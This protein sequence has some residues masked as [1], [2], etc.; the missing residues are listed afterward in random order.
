[1]VSI[2]EVRASNTRITADT[3]PHTAVFTGA[4]DG[5]GKASLTRLI[6]TKLPV[7]VYVIGRN[8]EKHKAF[9]DEL[10]GFNKQA[11][12]IWL[13]GQL[14][15][16]ADTKRLCDEIKAREKCIDTLYMSAGF[17]SGERL[18]T[19]E[20]NALSQSLTYYSRVLMM[21]QLLPLLKASPNNPRVVS[22]LNAGNETTSI[23][24]DDLN[25]KKPGN[26]TLVNLAKSTSTYTTLTM[27]KI[28]KENPGVTFIHHYP[29]GVSTDLF[30]K[31][32]GNKWYW[33]LFGLA[34]SILGTSPEDAAEKILYMITSAKYGGKGVA[35]AAGQSPGLTMAKTKQADSL[36]A[37]NDKLK[38]LQQEKVMAQLKAMNAGD[39]IWR[40]TMDTIEP[41][42]GSLRLTASPGLTPLERTSAIQVRYQNRV[43]SGHG[44]KTVRLLARN[45]IITTRCK[46]STCNGE[47]RPNP[48]LR[49]VRQGLQT[50]LQ[51]KVPMRGSPRRCRLR[52]PPDTVRR[53]TLRDVESG[54]K[55]AKL[56]GR[57]DTLTT[58]IQS[59]ANGTTGLQIN[60]NESLITTSGST[61]KSTS[62]YSDS[63][64]APPLYDLAL[65]EAAWYLDRFVTHMLPCFPFIWLSPG[66]TIQQLRWERPFLAEAITAVAT[67]SMQEKLARTE[68]LKFHLTRSAVLENQSSIDMLLAILTYVAWSTDPFIQRGSN[69]SRMIML[70]MSLV[71]D[72]QSS[73][74]PPPDAHV[75]AKMTPGLGHPERN[76]SDS[77]ARGFIEQQRAVLACFLLSSII[78][79]SFG[80][81]VALRWNSKM[82]EALKSIETNEGCPS[83]ESFAIQVRLQVLSQKALN[84]REPQEVDETTPFATSMYVKVLQTQLK[85]LRA[86]FSPRLQRRDVLTAYAHYVELCINEVTRLACSEAPLLSEPG[87]GDEPNGSMAGFERIECLWRSLYAVKS[88]LDVFYMIPPAAYM[89]FPFFC[90]FQLVRCIVILK[91]LSTFDDPAWD[92]EA[93]RKTVDMHMIL[94]WM[95]EKAELASREAG[96]QSDDDLFRRVCKML[97]LSQ[98]WVVAKQRAASQKEQEPPSLYSDAPELAPAG[99]DMMDPSEMAWM[100]ALETGDGAWLEEV[101]GWSPVIV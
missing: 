37:I 49:L 4:T 14:S 48:G 76:P 29:G 10:R 69:L 7:K 75:I 100:N 17:I 97:R 54:A 21:M 80:S 89:G 34:L 28:A 71:Y 3:V 44:Q 16:L 22:V 58:M 64:V 93:V 38:E 24:L 12:I 66:T 13:E 6:A 19:S 47:T 84:I 1:M 39:I 33:P 46:S 8:G 79:S 65:D 73:K 87:I 40:K 91:H 72:L 68:R 23:F 67:P 2:S 81:I 25:L 43:R 18:E 55:I 50:V 96:E 101:L 52:K 36:F 98:R 11:N 94:N 88:W 60:P 82:E 63:E 85:E 92:C 51:G 31:V 70:A 90:W 35:L 41:Y 59:I 61:S 26:Y 27:S 99:E 74:P 15:L 32:W 5:I 20:G 57:I 30:K 45:Q 78:S 42:A 53:R 56:E 77:S 62:T 95:A 9:L 86:S 83:D